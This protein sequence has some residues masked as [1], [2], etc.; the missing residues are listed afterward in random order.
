MQGAF[1]GY[2]REVSRVSMFCLLQI[3]CAIYSYI[4]VLTMVVR[5]GQ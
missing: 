2:F 1:P 5:P 4:A 3:L